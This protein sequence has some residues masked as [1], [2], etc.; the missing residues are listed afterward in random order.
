MLLSAAEALGAELHDGGITGDDKT[1]LKASMRSA[2]EH[3][4][5]VVTT[6]GV[7]MGELDLIKGILSE[8]GTLHFGRLMMKPGKPATFATIDK[9]EGISPCLFFALPGNP[10]SAMVCFQLLVAPV[11]KRLVGQS[12]PDP[13]RVTCRV[14]QDIRLDPERPEY[15][16][17]ILGWDGVEGAFVSSSTGIQQSS[18]LLSMRGANA[19]LELPK[20]P[21]SVER[22]QEVSALLLSIPE[23]ISSERDL[24]ST[25]TI[26]RPKPSGVKS[27]L[28]LGSSAGLKHG[29]ALL[30]YGEGSLEATQGLMSLL[31]SAKLQIKGMT[32]VD[33]KEDAEAFLLSYSQGSLSLLLTI[34]GISMSPHDVIPEISSTLIIKQAPGLTS[35]VTKGHVDTLCRGIA[36]LT[37]NGTLLL[38]LS[39]QPQDAVAHLQRVLPALGLGLAGA[40]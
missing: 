5:V 13:P 22:G 36:G 7:S 24:P 2:I 35:P 25:C 30:S 34:G 4:D 16:R 23:G 1:S 32:S 11:L 27:D 20:G 39:S 33:S 19:L 26:P 29:V 18:R 17:C 37:S 38:N 8:L 6:G 12:A 9:E 14:G 10:V 3:S 21:G 31:L 40:R 28:D 15:Q